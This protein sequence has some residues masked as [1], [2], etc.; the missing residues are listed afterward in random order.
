MKTKAKPIEKR[1]DKLE[2]EMAQIKLIVAEKNTPL[3][4]WWEEITGIFADDPVF[5]EAMK[6]GRKYRQSYQDNSDI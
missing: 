2:S 5:E 1:L 4:P 6:I 3:T